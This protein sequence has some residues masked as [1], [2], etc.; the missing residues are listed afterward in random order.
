[1]PHSR[2][3]SVASQATADKQS[4]QPR[5]RKRLQKKF[6]SL[7]RPAPIDSSASNK[8]SSAVGLVAQQAGTVG[9]PSLRLSPDLSDAKWHEYLSTS[10]TEQDSAEQPRV[11]FDVPVSQAVPELIPE[12][13][14]LAV[15]TSKPRPS[16]D[17]YLSSPTS[18]IS[19]RSSMR[20]RAKTPVYTIGQLEGTPCVKEPVTVDRSSV[21]LIA[22]QYQALIE[23][24]DGS[25]IC[26]DTRPDSLP[27]RPSSYTRSSLARSQYSA[28]E[29]RADLQPD[30]YEPPPRSRRRAS[31]HSPTSDDGTLVSF[32]EEA[33]YFKPLSFSP[34]P[35]SPPPRS[36]ARVQRNTESHASDHNLSLQI[37]TDLLTKELSTAMLDRQLGSGEDI[38][39]LQIWVM[40]EAYERLRD[41]VREKEGLQN[42]EPVFD[43]WL[44]A[45]Y[46]LH[47][48]L[49]NDA[50]S[51]QS[52]YEGGGP[53]LTTL[54]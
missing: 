31:A 23:S 44:A 30:V 51:H 6:P 29:L 53:E 37:C 2:G 3:P 10:G 35:P 34:E 14:H 7:R 28:G 11:S 1:M 13:S 27:S 21:D 19:T 25:S 50:N 49:T 54:N 52:H 18:S 8:L 48:K 33:I 20:R 40:I 24:Q 17:S 9:Q 16:L 4:E 26:T 38:S 39:S 41:Q 42:M 36:R 47:D 12:F 15:N 43:N 5:L 22:K 46:S 32:D 45:L